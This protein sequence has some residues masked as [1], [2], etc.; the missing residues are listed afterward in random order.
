[1]LENIDEET[2]MYREVGGLLVRTDYEAA[3]ENL[4]EKVESL[5]LRV[6]NLD[7]QENRVR[8][9]FESLQEELQDMLG[10]AGGAGGMPGGPGPGP[11]AG[12]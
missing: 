1:E 2:T 3:S 11:G 5:E 6:E 9:K 10:G 8:E 7:R 12:D 4:Q